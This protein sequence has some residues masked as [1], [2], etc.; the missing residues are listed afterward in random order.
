MLFATT[1]LDGNVALGIVPVV[2]AYFV[3][4]FLASILVTLAFVPQNQF[5]F[6]WQLIRSSL[7]VSVGWLAVSAFIVALCFCHEAVLS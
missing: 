6:D 1:L 5:S 3:I 2:A 4:G 7:V